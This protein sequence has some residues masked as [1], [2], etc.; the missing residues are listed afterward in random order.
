MSQ[1][2]ETPQPR[3]PGVRYKKET[4]YREETTVIDGRASTRRVPYT[5]YV[6]VPPRDWDETIRRGVTGVAIA[7][8][9]LAAAGT[10]AS[11]GGLLSRMLHPA[12]AYT[13]GVVY[14]SSWLACLGIEHIERVDARRAQ[15]AR[16]GGWVALLIGMG[17]VVTYGHTLDQLPAG[18]VGSCLDLLA[19]GLWFL[20][21]GLDRVH[22]APGVAQWVAEEEQALAGRFLLGT[23]LARL[24]RRSA[25][26]RA[27]ES[28]EFRAA[29][30]ILVQAEQHRQI[31]APDTSGHAAAPPGQPVQAPPQPPTPPVP[32]PPGQPAAPTAPTPPSPAPVPPTAPVR[33]AQQANA[34][35]ATGQQTPPPGRGA[36]PIGQSIA[37]TV[38]D[39]LDRNPAWAV[40]APLDEA[41]LEAMTEAVRQAHGDR[42]GL[43]DT[44]RRTRDRELKKRRKTA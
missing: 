29:E 44:V 23:R 39:L 40:D 15:R 26:M 24:N 9:V 34:G 3:Q 7:V 32:P 41:E 28:P 12:V 17:S 42:K 36:H 38:R 13:V 2:P 20:V 8:T 10:T 43:E 25:A 1:T 16:V 19:K 18:V 4:R 31:A 30:A 6:P 33:P 14:T 35:A 11:I 21:M 22:L 5:A 37:A 27:V